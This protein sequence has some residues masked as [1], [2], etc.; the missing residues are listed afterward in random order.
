M[1]AGVN[2]GDIEDLSGLEIRRQ[3]FVGHFDF[4]AL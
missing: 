4:A 3:F 1:A 2:G